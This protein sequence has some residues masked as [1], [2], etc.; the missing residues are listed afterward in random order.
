[1]YNNTKYNVNKYA[2]SVIRKLAVGHEII[3]LKHPLLYVFYIQM[4]Y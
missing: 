1:M 4:N 2:W 3:S